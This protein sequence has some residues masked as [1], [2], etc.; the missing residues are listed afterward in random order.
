MSNPIPEDL[1][2][3][4][5][6]GLLAAFGTTELDSATAMSGGLSGAAVVKIRVGGIAYV[7]QFEED[8]C[9]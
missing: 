2:P 1:R 3:A 9:V 7:T 5:D 6:R 4:V 8:Q